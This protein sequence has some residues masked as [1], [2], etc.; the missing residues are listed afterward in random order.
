MKP[1]LRRSNPPASGH[2]AQPS[3]GTEPDRD[4]G[5]QHAVADPGHGTSEA[6]SPAPLPPAVSPSP[7]APTSTALLLLL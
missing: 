6:A 3:R 5:T 4:P 2:D 1:I 7:A